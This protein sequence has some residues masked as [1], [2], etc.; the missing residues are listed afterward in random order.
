MKENLIF[1][2]SLHQHIENEHIPTQSI[3]LQHLIFLI[4]ESHHHHFDYYFNWKNGVFSHRLS[5]D[6]LYLSQLR[7]KKMINNQYDNTEKT[8]LHNQFVTKLK[9]ACETILHKTVSIH[10]INLLA[11]MLYI[12]KHTYT[13]CANS[14]QKSIDELVDRNPELCASRNLQSYWHVLQSLQLT[15]EI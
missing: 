1:L 7:Q 13:K 8:I 3:A 15:L 6:L 5:Y 4:I 9:D 10:D 12:H 11:H 2:H 14:Y